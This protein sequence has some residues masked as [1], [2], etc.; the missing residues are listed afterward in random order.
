ME[1]IN[2]FDLGYYLIITVGFVLMLLTIGLILKK[3]MFKNLLKEE[4]DEEIEE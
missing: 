2:Y 3:T 1:I 4:E